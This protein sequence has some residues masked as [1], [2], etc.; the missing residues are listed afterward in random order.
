[1][2]R[3]YLLGELTFKEVEEALVQGFDKLI[4]PIGTVEAHGP[5]LP[6]DTDTLIPMSIA[7]ELASRL[8][9]LVAPPIHYG[10]TSSLLGFSGTATISEETL[11]TVI[12]EVILS[13]RRHGFKLFIILNGHGGNRNA[14]RSALRELWRNHGVK[15]IVVDWWIFVRDVTKEV[16]GEVGAHGGVDETAMILSKYPELVREDLYSVDEVHLFTEG[17]SSYPEP[18]SIIIYKENEG[19]PKFDRE[20]AEKYFVKVIDFL[21]NKLRNIISKII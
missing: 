20:L 21:E 18:G 17:L 2:V 16:F 4:I 10:I 7:V 13:F 6:L 19:L 5:H 15:S 3:S 1:M 11:K 9:A 12:V 14:I 8:K